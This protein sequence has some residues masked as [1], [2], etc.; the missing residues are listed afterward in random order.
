MIEKIYKFNKLNEKL[1]EK[2]V[3]DDNLVLNYM[4][5]IKGIGFFEY[6]LNLNVYMII[7]R[8]IMILKLGE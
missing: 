3:D 8:G 4:V 7:V 5:L 6:Y 2:V 1:I